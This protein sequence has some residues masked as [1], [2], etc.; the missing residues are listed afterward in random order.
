MEHIA[1]L[2]RVMGWA[3]CV[4]WIFC[5]G[6]AIF[7]G[8]AFAATTCV[9]KTVTGYKAVPCASTVQRTPTSQTSSAD[10]VPC[11]LIRPDGSKHQSSCRR[12]RAAEQRLRQLK[13]QLR[14]R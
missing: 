13:S 1:K 5:L 12:N 2:G 4:V 3:M 8:K 6:Y 14:G 10:V 11:V 7:G 9:M